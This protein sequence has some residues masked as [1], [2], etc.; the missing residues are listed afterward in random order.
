MVLLLNSLYKI[1]LCPHYQLCPELFLYWYTASQ[2]L[3]RD[4]NAPSM[5]HYH[6]TDNGQSRN[7]IFLVLHWSHCY[8]SP[9]CNKSQS[10]IRHLQQS[11]ETPQPDAQSFF[12]L[13]GVDC[14]IP[15]QEKLDN[16]IVVPVKYPQLFQLPVLLQQQTVHTKTYTHLRE[17]HNPHSHC[18]YVQSKHLH[19]FL[20]LLYEWLQTLFPHLPLFSNQF[21][22]ARQ[23][24][25]FLYIPFCIPPCFIISS[26]K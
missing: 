3:H 9:G 14:C 25:Q 16:V 4:G 17:C 23:K 13:S 5:F 11:F 18:N 8:T 15:G 26:L 6:P 10:D 20:P 7:H 22:P 21:L 2:F 24:H 12:A 19:Y 1:H